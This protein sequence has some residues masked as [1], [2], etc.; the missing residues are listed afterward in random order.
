[1][2]NRNTSK[3]LVYLMSLG[4]L[5]SCASAGQLIESPTVELSGIKVSDFNYS[6]Q[7]FVLSFDVNNPNPY[8]LPIKSVR[9]HVQLAE[10]RFASGETNSDFSIPASGKGAF[11]ISVEL[12]ILRST[13]QVASI[14]RDGMHRP[15]PYELSGSLAVDL[16]FIKPVPFSASGV[17]AIAAN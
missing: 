15:V 1:M 8:A 17:I 11:D 13:T 5:A 12:D 16:P 4:M 2:I 6:G 14:L 9:Y 3:L 10:Q 7:T